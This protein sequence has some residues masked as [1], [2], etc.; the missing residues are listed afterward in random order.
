LP[1]TVPLDPKFNQAAITGMS[2]PA[3]GQCGAAGFYGSDL[4]AENVSVPFVA[5]QVNGTWGAA[6][7]VPGLARLNLGNHGAI[8]SVWF[9]TSGK[10]AAGGSTPAPEAVL[11]TLTF[12]VRPS[13]HPRR[14]ASG[15]RRYPYPVSLH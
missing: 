1:G 7:L 10:C 8:T 11:S 13:W 9:A 3:P 2:C 6:Q 4:D 14:A 5:T 15:A 12:L